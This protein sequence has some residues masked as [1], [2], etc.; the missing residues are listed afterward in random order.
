MCMHDVNDLE[1]PTTTNPLRPTSERSTTQ[2]PGVRTK[3]ATQP[4]DRAAPGV[5]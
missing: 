3:E 1:D 2:L 5:N 4:A